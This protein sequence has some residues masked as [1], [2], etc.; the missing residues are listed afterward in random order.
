MHA[1]FATEPSH[2]GLDAIGMVDMSISSPPETK[3]QPICVGT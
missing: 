2:K 3:M 1:E